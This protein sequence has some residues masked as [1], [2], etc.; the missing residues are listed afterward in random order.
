M[1][2]RWLIDVALGLVLALLLVPA[3]FVIGPSLE[4]RLL[5]VIDA[6][7]VMIEETRD[8]RVQ[9]YLEGRKLLPCLLSTASFSWH[10]DHSVVPTGITNADGSPRQLQPVLRE[11]DLFLVGPFFAVVP[12]SVRTIMDPHLVVT[13]YYNCHFGWLTENSIE[14]PV[15]L[16]RVSANLP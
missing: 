5:R 9:F 13:M 6:H 10:F 4:R 15:S 11:E 1:R 3:V 16:S 8:G 12:D 14:F 7:G 2:G